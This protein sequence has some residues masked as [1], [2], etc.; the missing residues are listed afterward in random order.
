LLVDH[1]KALFYWCGNVFWT[2]KKEGMAIRTK[3]A[4]FRSKVPSPGLTL[5]LAALPSA[6]LATILALLRGVSAATSAA[7]ATGP[8]APARS[9]ISVSTAVCL[10][11]ALLAGISLASWACACVYANPHRQLLDPLFNKLDKSWDQRF[12]GD[13]AVWKNKLLHSPQPSLVHLVSELC[14]NAVHDATFM[15]VPLYVVLFAQLHRVL[16]AGQAV[17]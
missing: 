16:Q 11:S 3:L 10:L 17:D 5:L 8:F 7:I 4:F 13:G 6:W 15:Q 1:A 12:L 14:S 9:A 2:I